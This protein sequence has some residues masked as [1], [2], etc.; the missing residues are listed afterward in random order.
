M[1]VDMQTP[2]PIRY[3]LVDTVTQIILCIAAL[4]V[5][6]PIGLLGHL[7]WSTL[8]FLL[9]YNILIATMVAVIL[10]H[11]GSP[12][13]SA[14]I[15]GGGVVIGHLVGLLLGAFVGARFYGVAGA[16]G[17]AVVLY[18]VVGRLGS[19]VSAW[20]G[21]GLDH[22]T[23]AALEPASQI[24][25]RHGRQNPTT[26][27][28]FGAVIPMLSMAGAI[29]VKSSGLTVVHL[30]AMLPTA[31]FALALLSIISIVLPRLRYSDWP[32]GVHAGLFGRST[33]RIL[34]IALCLAPAV[35]G[36]LLFVAFG[37]SMAELSLFTVTASIAAT[38]WG[39]KGR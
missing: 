3:F 29:F 17:G 24:Q 22:L 26:L 6:F 10:A 18:F 34:G 1:A 5:L 32:R 38:T 23:A 11:N 39:A 25:I 9:F 2:R 36:F 19:Q 28:L 27:F 20:V 8:G 14:I 4:I 33:T 16:I 21:R 15:K 35:Y 7:P 31:R 37:L 12:D 13:E 30:Q